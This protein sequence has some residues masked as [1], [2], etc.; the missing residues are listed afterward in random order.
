MRLQRLYSKVNIL[1]DQILAIYF[2]SNMFLISHNG[3]PKE[4]W[5]I[6]SPGQLDFKN[7]LL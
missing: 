1:L 7:A 6:Q 3:K 4:I 5:S 2:L